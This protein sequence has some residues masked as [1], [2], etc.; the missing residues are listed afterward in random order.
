MKIALIQFRS[1][2]DVIEHEIENYL[3]K[4]GLNRKELF[5]LNIYENNFSNRIS[6]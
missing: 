1:N 4:T 3:D 2:Q 5:P 6:K